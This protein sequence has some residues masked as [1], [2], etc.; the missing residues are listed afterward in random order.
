MLKRSGGVS[1]RRRQRDERKP[2][3]FWQGLLLL[4]PV[5]VLSVA[6]LASL[7]Q[8]KRL[9]EAQARQRAQELADEL[10]ERIDAELSAT[11]ESAR[12][13]S[14]PPIAFVADREGGLLRP[15]PVSALPVPESFD[16][17][18]LTVEQA[19]LWRG[20]ERASLDP[21]GRETAL[22]TW[23]QFISSQPPD[24]FAAV[25][26]YRRALLLAEQGQSSEALRA[27]R[28]FRQ[29][30]PDAAGE[31]G[32]PLAPLAVLKTLE[33]ASALTNPTVATP[34]SGEAARWLGSNALARPTLLSPLVLSRLSGLDG[35]LGLAGQTAAWGAEWERAE[36]ARELYAAS[37]VHL[38]T[39][40]SVSLPLV[41]EPGADGGLASLASRLPAAHVS[42]PRVFW[43]GTALASEPASTSRITP[44]SDSRREGAQA[45]RGTSPSNV[46][47]QVPSTAALSN[48]AD[49]WARGKAV[50][51][52]VS[53]NAHS[54]PWDAEWLAIRQEESD[55]RMR[56]VCW[57][58]VRGDPAA[59]S[60]GPM[61]PQ[62][63]RLAVEPVAK[64]L[65]E[66]FGFSLD[67]AGQ[68]VYPSN[69]V[70]VVDWVQGGKG[71]GQFWKRTHPTKPPP[72]LALAVR[73]E[74]G[75]EYLR[76]AI[77]LASPDLLYQVQRARQ[78]LFGLLILASAG[79][80]L[81]GFVASWRAF[82]KQQRL[83][84]LKSNFVSSVSHELRA[85]IA[86]VRLLTE[87]L[88]RGKVAEPVRQR[89]Y[90]RFILQECRRLSALI[91]N[92]L[93]FS[94][95]EQGRREYEFEPTDVAAL[96]AATVKLMEPNAAEKQVT[97]VFSQD[98]GLAMRDLHPLLDG[99]AIQQALVN[100]VDNAIKHSPPGESVTVELTVSGEGAEGPPG[101][102]L[103]EACAPSQPPGSALSITV[104]DH[105]PG[106]PSEEHARIFERFY[107]RGSELRRETQGVG[108]GLSIVKHIVEAHGG[109]V[110]VQ[111]EV[112]KGS[113][114]VME[115][116]LAPGA[117]RSP[118][119]RNL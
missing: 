93:D 23:Q 98:P 54:I 53:R 30:W 100:L 48:L 66:Y 39:N 20:A 102:G 40:L 64:R 33:I 74:G 87:S 10:A 16:P 2:G 21:A 14:A 44:T 50:M 112:G 90:F 96:A 72:I 92:V 38:R 17:A 35:R 4:L 60:P 19:G 73:G 71:G 26:T 63:V 55:G 52:G 101:P 5:A 7:R 59:S 105:G 88:E 3:F 106:I 46:T 47:S 45:V 76:V 116:P 41:G 103:G 36:K 109:R 94:R 24:R 81:V 86:S 1:W 9:V 95:I 77:H 18:A 75:T 119:T 80:V 15:P 113:R 97:L 28:G 117:G 6:G 91:E 65:P 37:A 118:G 111:S 51:H 61:P 8:D 42:L 85:P 22:T 69:A 110:T 25:A 12:G 43:V 49:G 108:I 107:R 34:E 84:E 79:A 27:L 31:T 114:F 82:A 58:V 13:S 62:P 11:N 32:L 99:R 78:G 83:S 70:E 57:P 89:E 68:P 56:V 115:L 29:R 67:L 104:S